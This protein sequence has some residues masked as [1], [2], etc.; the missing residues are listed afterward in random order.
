[1]FPETPAPTWATL[2]ES[3]FG[4]P[5]I[6]DALRAGVARRELGFRAPTDRVTLSIRHGA[7]YK[8]EVD[9]P[10]AVVAAL[11]RLLVHISAGRGVIVQPRDGEIAL[12]EAAFLLGID[13]DELLDRFKLYGVRYR[14]DG[15]HV[16]VGQ[17]FVARCLRAIHRD[18]SEHTADCLAS[19]QDHATAARIVATGRVD[20]VTRLAEDLGRESNDRRSMR[21]VLDVYFSGKPA[22]VRRPGHWPSLPSDPSSRDTAVLPRLPTG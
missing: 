7:Q 17:T 8:T 11:F 21:E 5:G 19:E 16:F 9:L 18:V 10:Q 2:R 6:E 4:A 13:P 3:V 22:W 15:A 12:H 1:M 20:P 14:G